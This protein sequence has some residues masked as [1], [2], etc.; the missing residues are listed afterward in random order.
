MGSVS[1]STDAAS[2]SMLPACLRKLS[3]WSPTFSGLFALPASGVAREGLIAADRPASGGPGLTAVGSRAWT[4][5]TLCLLAALWLATRPYLGIMHDARLY[6]VQ[7]LNLLHPGRFANDLYFKYGSQDSFSLFTP[8]YAPLVATLGSSGASMAADALGQVLWFAALLW[9]L[10]TL[11]PERRT[12]VA[13][14]LGVALL[15][16]GYGG[17]SVFRYGEPFVTPRTFAEAGVLAALACALQG[18]RIAACL[19]VGAAGLIHPIMAASGGA[20][21]AIMAAFKD[22]RALV[23]LGAG[24]VVALIAAFAHIG[25]FGRLLLRF[26]DAWFQIVKARCD[27]GVVLAWHFGD[28]L[29]VVMDLAMLG[30]AWTLGAAQERRVIRAVAAAAAAGLALTL[31][32]CDLGRDILLMNLQPWRVLWLLSLLANAFTAVV[33]LRLPKD[34]VS[35]EL[36]LL[37]FPI[38]LA[39]SLFGFDF[40][41]LPLLL[42]GPCA[43]FA[44]ERWKMRPLPRI[45]RYVLLTVP[46]IGVC[47]IAWVVYMQ[48]SMDGFAGMVTSCC[49]AA[50]A[51]A[52]LGLSATGRL[53]RRL[54]VLGV[55]VLIAAIGTAD[56]RTAWQKV[57]DRPTPPPGAQTFIGSSKNVYWEGAPGME[58]TWINLK[59]PSYYSCLQGTG[60][61]FFRGTAMEFARRTQG[62]RGLDTIDFNDSDIGLCPTKADPMQMGPRSPKQLSDACR[63]LP[64]LDSIILVH[65]VPG[66]AAQVWRAPAA[67]TVKASNGQTER[68]D[69]YYRYNCTGL[70]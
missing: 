45:P 52:L 25:P 34:W 23:L 44:W 29:R 9:F 33:I 48:S 7:V 6:T 40:E 30:V 41:L 13:A 50:A 54:S 36:L 66:L 11:F 49:I 47:L 53:D 26:D 18:R 3:G 4:V 55:V 42:L 61:M 51:L 22:R 19:L 15:Y 14:T 64:D 70:R 37:C 38:N 43:A 60:A 62:L 10:A 57:I 24:G 5:L 56:H 39:A 65:A 63:A 68:I 17:L 8:L 16:S 12:W 27:F 58:L 35:R 31:L 67:A 2:L 69:T 46:A 32:G 1:V 28:W 20:V 59:S 21:L